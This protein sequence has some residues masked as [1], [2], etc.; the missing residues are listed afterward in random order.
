[1]T[2]QLQGDVT[3]RPIA[4]VPGK[5]KCLPHRTDAF[6]KALVLATFLCAIP[7]HCVVPELVPAGETPCVFGGATRKIPVIWRNPTGQPMTNALTARLFQT[8][9]ATAARWGD[10]AWKNLQLLSEQTVLE[11]IAM[12]FPEVQS[13]TRF[14]IQWIG[15]ADKILGSTPVLV[16]PQNLLRELKLLADDSPV[17]LFDPS[18]QLKPRF[19]EAM[20][21]FTDLEQSSLESFTGKLA[22]IGPWPPRAEVPTE[23]PSDIERLATRGARIIWFKSPGTPDT[24]PSG[25]TLVPSFYPVPTGKGLIVFAQSGLVADFANQPKS[26]IQLIQL[27]RFA[28]HP[29]FLHSS[30]PQLSTP[31]DR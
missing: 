30:G 25:Q 3:G 7:G 22:I 27:A 15:P 11:S 12:P 5:G 10:T 13:E 21:E 20:V 6:M 23:L 4:T 26:Q 9:S 19:Q 24:T 1:M 16:Y 28:L 2:R 31:A 18:T 8:T 14:L 17:G 29:E